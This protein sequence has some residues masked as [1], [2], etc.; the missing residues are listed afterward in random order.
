LIK[1]IANKKLFQLK[2]ELQSIGIR[3][4]GC[5]TDCIYFEKDDR[6]V[7]L[8]KRKF[9]DYFD[10]EDKNSFQ[11]IGKL[12]FEEAVRSGNKLLEVKENEDCY[13]E[14]VEPTVQ[15]IELKDEFDLSEIQRTVES[16][17]RLIIKADIA[18]AGKTTSFLNR[19]NTLIV[20][21]YN[22]LCFDLNNRG[23][24]SVTL[25]K[26]IGL[27]YDG[28]K[29]LDVRG[30]DVSDVERIV[31]D[32]IYLYPTTLL[33]KIKKY[34]NN[35]KEIQFYA[36][37]DE[38]QLEPIE[39]LNI[40]E[41]REYYNKI[42]TSM[43]PHQ[44]VLHEN[45]RCKTDEDR[46]RM[47][48]ITRLIRDANSK[49]EALNVVLKNFKKI[50]KKEDIVTKK[51]VCALNKTSDWVNEYLHK[52]DGDNKYY[53]GLELIGR[54][55]FKNKK[56]NIKIN[57]TYTIKKIL[58]EALVLDDG[59]EEHVVDNKDV[60]KIFKLNYSRTCHS[61]QGMSINEG[62]TIF[63]IFNPFVS[64][65]WIYTAITRATSLDNIFIYCVK[66]NSINFLKL[67]EAIR[68]RIQGHMQYDIARFKRIDNDYIDI[69]FVKDLLFSTKKCKFCERRFDLNDSE[70]WSIDRIDNNIPHTKDN[71]QIICR[72]CNNGKK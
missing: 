45:K 68:G 62:I 58:E 27:R 2:D 4:L 28:E 19:N 46:K 40:E 56:S 18:G 30:Y 71:C 14:Y 36:T 9:R 42:I 70:S 64:I 34:M 57:Y 67:D 3:V 35:H 12:K 50:Y 43:F 60:E 49:E 51:N 47:K 32:E 13:I 21:P 8:F 66:E 15:M 10:F 44:I 7:E 54:K 48:E 20:C 5:N 65:S 26:L 6:K 23:E 17:D 38:Y 59:E 63:D 37:G 1:D 72:K 31:F 61:L 69:R 25:N 55:T 52:Y 16:S 11:A 33:E 41:T 39:T 29:N 24:Q 22:A 53:V